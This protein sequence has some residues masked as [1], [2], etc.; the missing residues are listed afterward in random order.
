MRSRGFPFAI[1]VAAPLLLSGAASE[2]QDLKPVIKQ[3]GGGPCTNVPDTDMSDF[4]CVQRDVPIDHHASGGGT[5]KIDYAIHFATQ[6]S[7]GVL[8]Y[9]V[10]GPGE[11]GI[12]EAA[13]WLDLYSEE[14]KDNIDIV[15]FD[16]RG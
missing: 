14:L 12:A 3:L 11:S 6:P 10:G 8:F 4:T 1:L 16:Q 13:E 5:I 9:V 7:K 2:A 15:F